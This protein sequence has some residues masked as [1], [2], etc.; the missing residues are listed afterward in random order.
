MSVIPDFTKVDLASGTNRRSKVE[1]WARG[2][3]FLW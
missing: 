3:S 1:Q 2:A